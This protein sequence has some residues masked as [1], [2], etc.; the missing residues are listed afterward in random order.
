MR[1]SSALALGQGWGKARAWA[2]RRI[3]AAWLA[4]WRRLMVMVRRLGAAG[5]DWVK[6]GMVGI[7]G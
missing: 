1:S 7:G 3:R 5:E 2:R 4:R 6:W